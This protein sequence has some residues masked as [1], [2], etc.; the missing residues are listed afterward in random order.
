LLYDFIPFIQH[1]II[2]YA[3]SITVYNT[4]ILS[5]G[6]IDQYG[7]I[8]RSNVI[9]SKGTAF[10]NVIDETLKLKLLI[11]NIHYTYTKIYEK[12]VDDNNCGRLVV[13]V[14]MCNY[15]N[16][17]L[18]SLLSMSTRKDSKTLS[19]GVLCHHWAD[20][21]IDYSFTTVTSLNKRCSLL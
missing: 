6:G 2:Q 19:S 9:F 5:T 13:T 18:S 3:C 1:H 17:A 12:R 14:T 10:K 20:G 16:H 7:T 4:K 8:I 15:T 11:I 21:H